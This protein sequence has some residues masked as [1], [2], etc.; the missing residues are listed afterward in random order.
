MAPIFNSLYSQQRTNFNDN[1]LVKTYA[2][3]YSFNLVSLGLQALQPGT[4]YFDDFN[5]Q[6][7]G[8]SD[9]FEGATFNP[10]WTLSQNGGTISSLTEQAHSGNDNSKFSYVN[11]PGNA[12]LTH[13]YSE[14]SKGAIQVW[15]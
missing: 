15:V 4:F 10:Y 13:A 8:F 1:T 3:D 7:A 11:Y 6:R 9:S 5:V 14:L 12:W 2:G